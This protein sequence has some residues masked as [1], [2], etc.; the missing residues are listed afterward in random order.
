VII[1][2]SREQIENLPVKKITIDEPISQRE[3][4]E[5]VRNFPKEIVNISDGRVVSFPVATVGKIN[6]SKNPNVI[7]V[8]RDIPELYRTSIKA[9]SEPEIVFAGHK[10]HPNV[11][12][13]HHYINKFTDGTDEYFIRITV[14]E[15]KIGRA[16][17]T[18][19][20]IHAAT[21]SEIALYKK[22]KDDPTQRALVTYRG[23]GSQSPFVDKKL[24]EFFASIN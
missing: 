22:E 7:R 16:G 23:E 1:T 5:I 2:G 18:R 13:Y 17:I 6:S 19:N 24:Q 11:K 14:P 21:V 3:A 4:R 8:I 12:E 15:D 10:S 20:I 9:W